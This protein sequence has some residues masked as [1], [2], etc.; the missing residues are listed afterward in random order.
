MDNDTIIKCINELGK[1]G[2]VW[3]GLT[4]GEPLLNKNIVEIIDQTDKD[5][6]IKLFTTG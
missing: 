6:T 5:I 3:L 2:V 1:M 4:G